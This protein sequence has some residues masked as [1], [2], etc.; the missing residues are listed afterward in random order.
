MIWV[1]TRHTV[2]IMQLQRPEIS[3]CASTSQSCVN[4]ASPTG[5]W[6]V[7]DYHQKH[8]TQKQS[9][10]LQQKHHNSATDLK[11]VFLLM[12]FLVNPIGSV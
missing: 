8:H 11:G 12:C 3:V 7:S 6:F 4:I 9:L 1:V 2:S 5:R 10:S